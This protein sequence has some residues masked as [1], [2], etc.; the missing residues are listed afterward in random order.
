MATTALAIIF[1]TA[2]RR[3]ESTRAVEMFRGYNDD[4][5]EKLVHHNGIDC[6]HKRLRKL[7]RVL[8]DFSRPLRCSR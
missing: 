5:I 2:F 6:D 8:H 3:Y 1:S 7:A 4:T